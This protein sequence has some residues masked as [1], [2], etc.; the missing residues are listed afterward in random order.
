ML[1]GIWSPIYQYTISAGDLALDGCEVDAVSVW[2]AWEPQCSKGFV[3]GASSYLSKCSRLARHA[4]IG[5]LGKFFKMKPSNALIE[6]WPGVRS[7]ASQSKGCMCCNFCLFSLLDHTYALLH[8]VVSPTPL[9][10]RNYSARCLAPPAA[11]FNSCS[12]AQLSTSLR[13]H[14]RVDMP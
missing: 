9:L 6:C 13:L 10:Y 11:S 12:H 7:A 2:F 14:R 5:F 8:V 4:E 1:A 3:G